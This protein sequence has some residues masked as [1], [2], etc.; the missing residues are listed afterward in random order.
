[1]VSTAFEVSGLPAQM[2]PEPERVSQ[3]RVGGTE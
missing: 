1:M 2:V 3:I